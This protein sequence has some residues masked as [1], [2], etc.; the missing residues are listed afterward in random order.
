MF[1]ASDGFNEISWDSLTISCE[2][3]EQACT[4]NF[5]YVENDNLI[6]RTDHTVVAK[7]DHGATLPVEFDEDFDLEFKMKV[8]EFSEQWGMY[9]VMM[10]E[11]IALQFRE[12]ALLYQRARDPEFSSTFVDIGDGWRTWRIECRNEGIATIYMDNMKVLEYEYTVDDN[13]VLQKLRR[14]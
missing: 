7:S 4:H 10:G 5:V 12:N 13:E 9:I 11:R 8:T 6:F 14:S 1:A 2:G 3:V